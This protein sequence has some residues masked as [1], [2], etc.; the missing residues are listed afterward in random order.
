MSVFA[1]P[2]AKDVLE[3]F[4][5]RGVGALRVGAP[6]IRGEWSNCT[7]RISRSQPSH[8]VERVGNLDVGVRDG[9]VEYLHCEAASGDWPVN[10]SPLKQRS[11]SDIERLLNRSLGCV[12]RV[13]TE[14]SETTIRCDGVSV[15]V[16]PDGVLTAVGI[17]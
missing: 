15:F 9:V 13:E 17:R 5:L 10:L 1:E 4:R 8:R 2:E 14:W 7:W 6:Y 3:C 11:V 12:T 16:G